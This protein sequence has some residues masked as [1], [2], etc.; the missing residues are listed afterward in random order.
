MSELRALESISDYEGFD[1]PR[2]W[3]G[4]EKVTEVERSFLTAAFAPADRRRLLE[5]GTG[6]GRLL[7]SLENL[8]DEIV[9]MDFDFGSLARLRS[10][11]VQGDRT[12]RIAANIYHLPFVDGAFTGATMIRVYHHLVDPA[13]AL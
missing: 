11:G 8:G 1:F 4:R 5:V 6:F 13:A 9:A 12:L 7:G 3:R 2:L 10:P